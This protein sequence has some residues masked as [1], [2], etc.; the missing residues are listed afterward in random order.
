[1]TNFQVLRNSVGSEYS[2]WILSTLGEME[3]LA[4]CDAQLLGLLPNRAN[5][6]ACSCI[7]VHQLAV[8]SLTLDVQRA[9]IFLAPQFCS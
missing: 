5:G 9:L 6:Q 8:S 3:G 1:M 4:K 2:V 7:P